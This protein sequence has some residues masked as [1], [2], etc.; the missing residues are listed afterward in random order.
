MS[1]KH[2]KYIIVVAM[3]LILGIPTVI[4]LM[5]KIPSIELFAAEWTAGDALDFYGTV[6]S[7]ISTTV[8]SV[9]ALWQNNVIKKESDRHT[10]RLEEW[11]KAR[12]WPILICKAVGSLGGCSELSFEVINTTNNIALNLIVSNIH[13]TGLRGDYLWQDS[14]VYCKEVLTNNEGLRIKLNNPMMDEQMEIHFDVGYEDVLGEPYQFSGVAV[15]ND[16]WGLPMFT[17]RRSKEE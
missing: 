11:E 10:A 3:L 13:I 5:F 9:I 17:L 8:L 15:K 12:S 6:L 14:N 1:K 7:F 4:N 2:K 16:K